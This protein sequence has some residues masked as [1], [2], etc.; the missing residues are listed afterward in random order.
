MRDFRKYDVWKLSH[1]FVLDIYSITKIFPNNE[2]FGLT[3][4]IRR[5]ALSIPTNIAEGC[6]RKTDTEFVRYL[7][8]SQGSAHEAEYLCQ[9]SYDLKYIE[10]STY[11]DLNENI[12]VIKKKIFHLEKTINETKTPKA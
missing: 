11:F 12:N 6:G 9:W 3:S 2:Q 10:E 1:E 4:Q 7:H 8:I 5:A